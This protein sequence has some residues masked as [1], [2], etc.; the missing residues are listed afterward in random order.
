[1]VLSIISVTFPTDREKLCPNPR[2]T[3]RARAQQ[4]RRCAALLDF[5]LIHQREPRPFIR[6]ARPMDRIENGIS[7]C[8]RGRFRSPLFI[9]ITDP[10]SP[11]SAPSA[12]LSGL[13]QRRKDVPERSLDE[14]QIICRP[15][16]DA[17]AT[18][19]ENSSKTYLHYAPKDHSS[20]TAA[21]RGFRLF[22]SMWHDP[23]R[24]GRMLPGDLLVLL[25]G[26]ALFIGSG[27][28]VLQGF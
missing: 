15:N 8:A 25:I 24:D 10:A 11:H 27:L 22:F 4:R 9:G 5:L 6:R 2:P 23:Q 13:R 14:A 16:G 26:M 7:S 18:P 28:V 20:L 17:T 3:T 21:A 12:S 1:M 19:I